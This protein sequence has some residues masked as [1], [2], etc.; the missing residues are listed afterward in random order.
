M[1]KEIGDCNVAKKSLFLV[2]IENGSVKSVKS[3]KKKNKP[4]KRVLLRCSTIEEN[5]TNSQSK[6]SQPLAAI[7]SFYSKFNNIS[8]VKIFQSTTSNDTEFVFDETKLRKPADPHVFRKQKVTLDK[9]KDPW[10][11]GNIL[12][13]YKQKK[14]NKKNKTIDTDQHAPKSSL[15]RRI[16]YNNDSSDEYESADDDFDYSTV[17]TIETIIHEKQRQKLKKIEKE[18]TKKSKKNLIENNSKN[19]VRDEAIKQFS[20]KFE[21]KKIAR[22]NESLL[23]DIRNEVEKYNLKKENEQAVVD[24][25]FLFCNSLIQKDYNRILKLKN[26][27]TSLNNKDYKNYSNNNDNFNN[28]NNNQEVERLDTINYLDYIFQNSINNN[29]NNNSK[30]NNSNNNQNESS[31]I[32]EDIKLKCR[33]LNKIRRQSMLNDNLTCSIN[34]NCNSPHISI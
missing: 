8:N 32:E 12:Q 30:N 1:F 13:Y 2:A 7:S 26:I 15:T 23:N 27:N 3:I 24:E 31:E 16:L 29:K 18:I 11:I 17:E 19:L 33:Q 14:A 22:K 5:E 20:I 10:L 25:A 34:S 9:Q 4:R 28:G 21:K 6:L